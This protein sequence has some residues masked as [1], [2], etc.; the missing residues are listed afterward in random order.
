MNN[1]TGSIL[2]LS[3]SPLDDNWL[4]RLDMLDYAYQVIVNIHTGSTYGV[5][6]LVRNHQLLGIKSVFELFDKAHEEGLLAPLTL[7]LMDKA[8][9]KFMQLPFY[10]KVK[11]FFNLDNRLFS[12]PEF[13]PD[14]LAEVV[15][16]NHFS[17]NSVSLEIAGSR[18]LGSIDRAVQSIHL[19][20]NMGFSVGIDHFG[21]AYSGMQ[22]LYFLNPDFIKLDP[23]FIQNLNAD[24]KKSLFVGSILNISHLMGSVVIAEGVETIEEFYSCRNISCDLI[25]GYLVHQPCINQDA[26][27]PAYEQVQQWSSK[28]RRE[29]ETD[30]QLVQSEIKFIEP[31]SIDIDIIE[32]FDFFKHNPGDTF[33]PVVNRYKEPMGVCRER[34]LKE[35]VYS[36]FGRDLLKN[37]AYGKQFRDFI[38]Q[39]PVADVKQPVEKILETFSLN[40][41]TEGII[42]TDNRRYIGVLGT[43]SLLRILNEKNLTQA[44]D[45]NPLTKL[46]GNNSIYEFVSKA[47][48]NLS[49]GYYLVYF[50]FDNFKP[51]NDNYGFRQGDRAIL[52]FADFL[53]MHESD[54]DRFVGHIGGDDFFMAFENYS[55]ESAYSE[56]MKLGK[57]FKRDVESFYDPETIQ[58]GYIQAKDRE[59]NQ[60]QFPLLTASAVILE[61]PKP[62]PAYSLEDI[63]A[64]MARYKK[65]SKLATNRICVATLAGEKRQA[66]LDRLINK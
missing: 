53:R 26:L 38:T 35:Y 15:K 37:Q 34:D 4:K 9:K 50:D 47:L 2:K 45:Q 1:E 54:S 17:V 42:M 20:H 5:E 21:S 11:L 14:Q 8:V 51:F 60:K 44:R 41:N 61:I 59:G 52:L 56:V 28:D 62:H 31:I 36:P 40:E 24:S 27:K 6:A 10:D 46:P 3:T 39:I 55:L 22:M 19:C 58:R 30:L 65:R 63:S 66:D 16:R 43:N 33:F 25:Q 49:S 7:L 48:D 12:D 29:R 57:Q 18:P 23:F 32:V 13:H 64:A